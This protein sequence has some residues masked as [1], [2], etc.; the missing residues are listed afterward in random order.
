M[1]QLPEWYQRLITP[2]SHDW[3]PLTYAPFELLYVVIMLIG[4]LLRARYQ[5]LGCLQA[6]WSSSGLYNS[7][8]QG[9]INIFELRIK[10]LLQQ[11]N[12]L[13]SHLKGRFP[14]LESGINKLL[15]AG[16]QSIGIALFLHHQLYARCLQEILTLIEGLALRYR[17]GDG[18][19]QQLTICH[20]KP[21]TS[22]KLL[23]AS[24]LGAVLGG[25]LLANFTSMGY[26]YMDALHTALFFAATA[27]RAEK[28]T[29]GWLILGI[30]KLFYGFICFQKGAGILMLCQLSYGAICLVNFCNWRQA[31]CR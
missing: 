7:K 5:I 22:V 18:L 9:G 21:A 2:Q 26:P 15:H 28:R 3:Y 19:N 20:R 11:F 6:W 29:E 23:M 4:F 8:E 14:W 16:K 25:F 31:G 13:P 12:D 30:V 27:M 1:L 24:L 17:Y 10:T